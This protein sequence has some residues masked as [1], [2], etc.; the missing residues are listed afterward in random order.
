MN[1]GDH[2]GVKTLQQNFANCSPLLHNK[3]IAQ[4]PVKQRNTA[5]INQSGAE[6]GN[7]YIQINDHC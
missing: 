4:E 5:S 6:G 7:L 3:L 2:L 1:L